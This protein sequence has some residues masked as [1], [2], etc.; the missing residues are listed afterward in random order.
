MIPEEILEILEKFDWTGQYIKEKL[1]ECLSKHGAN[2]INSCLEVA[3][4]Y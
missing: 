1:E 4:E 2:G 3:L